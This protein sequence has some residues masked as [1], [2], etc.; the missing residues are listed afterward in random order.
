MII[1][2][3]FEEREESRAGLKVV[4]PFVLESSFRSVGFF[5]FCFMMDLGN[6]AMLIK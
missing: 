6:M 5:C 4:L 3:N 2:K 1:Q